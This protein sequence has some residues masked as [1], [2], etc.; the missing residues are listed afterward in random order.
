MAHSGGSNGA[1]EEFPKLWRAPLQPF[2][3]STC[4]HQV[5]QRS[6]DG[7]FHRFPDREADEWRIY[8]QVPIVSEHLDDFCSTQDDILRTLR[9][10]PAREWEGTKLESG[11]WK[12]L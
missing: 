9:L 4:L 11:R 6:Y 3:E 2:A 12:A 10:R 8:F 7:G 1:P 5:V